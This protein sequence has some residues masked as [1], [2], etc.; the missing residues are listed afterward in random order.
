MSV[1]PGEYIPPRRI[2][3]G[4][5][6]LFFDPGNSDERERG[7][8]VSVDHSTD[9]QLA[10]ISIYSDERIEADVPFAWGSF[11]P[12]RGYVYETEVPDGG[13]LGG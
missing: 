13:P 6:V 2:E 12:G 4:D 9:D 5:P 1:G 3:E 11:Q 10:S 7:S 8:V